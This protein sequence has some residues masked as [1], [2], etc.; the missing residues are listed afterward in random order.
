MGFISVCGNLTRD[1]E[2]RTAG[3]S[4]VTKLSIAD[5]YR[6]K[7]EKLTAFYNVSVWGRQGEAA[8]EHLSKGS[9][10]FVNGELHPREYQKG[11]GET[12]ISL[13][14]ENA[15]WKFAGSSSNTG[16]GKQA[17]PEPTDESSLDW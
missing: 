12:G 6:V 14:I 1:P 3:N 8:A 5:N 7:G 13:D 16:G 9:C 10:V 2:T 15:T 4:T 17:G 11:T